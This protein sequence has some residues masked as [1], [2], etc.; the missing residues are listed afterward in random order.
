MPHEMD[1]TAGPNSQTCWW[2]RCA[3]LVALACLSCATTATAP[4]GLRE[5]FLT[6]KDVRFPQ[7][8]YITGVGQGRDISQARLTAF[9]DIG[10]QLQT[11]IEGTL[12]S[13][14][15]AMTGPGGGATVS[16]VT[17]EV[18][19]HTTFDHRGL[20]TVADT[21]I[22]DGTVHV[23]ATL[24]RA[25]MAEP[26]EREVA[27]T[28]A[29]L[30][31]AL[32]DF[33][34]AEAKMDLR[35]A[36]RL[37][38][39]VRRRAAEL[40]AALVMFE[41]STAS[42]PAGGQWGDVPKAAQVDAD[43]RRVR[44]KASVEI[45]LH[46]EP[47]FPEGSQLVQ[48]VTDHISSLGV[49]AVPCGQSRGSASFRAEGRISAVFSTEAMLEGAVF[50]RPSVDLRMLDSNSGAEI[51]SASL[52]GDAARAAGRDREAATRAALKGLSAI[53]APKLSEALGD[54][55]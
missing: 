30:R 22:M 47:G 26:F 53:C 33:A 15:Q 18:R 40:A 16:Q 10:A 54:A 28:W 23:F 11:K 34:A 42:A 49:A 55:P 29:L 13:H 48:A 12:V 27:R 14:E 46:P 43:L 37:A 41:S 44:S 32:E 39:E 6:G 50:C 4:A 36:G 7:S 20:A 51:L 3:V 19:Q 9:A 31:R 35:G 8:E 2:G 1:S 52:G 24:D 45:C 21:Q 25:A 17:N 5:H 38:K